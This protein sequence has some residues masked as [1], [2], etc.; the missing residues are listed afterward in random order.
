MIGS[1]FLLLAFT[2]ILGTVCIF[3]VPTLKD[4]LGQYHQRKQRPISQIIKRHH[5]NTSYQNPAMTSVASIWQ[6]RPYRTEVWAYLQQSLFLTEDMSDQRDFAF[7]SISQKCQQL[8][9]HTHGCNSMFWG[10]AN[11]G[12]QFCPGIS[13]ICNTQM[14][15]SNMALTNLP[16]PSNAVLSRFK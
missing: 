3:V 13:T 10:T 15:K 11:Q 2:F 8:F 5:Q 12:R 16:R 9:S 1:T 6:N 7:S 14:H 4:F